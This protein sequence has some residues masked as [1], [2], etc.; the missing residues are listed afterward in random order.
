MILQGV[1]FCYET[2]FSHVSKVDFLAFAKANGYQI[3]LVYFHLFDSSLNEA[4]V[5]QRVS[6]GGHN[7]PADKI[8]SRIPRTMKNIKSALSIVDEAKILDNSSKDNPFQ[9]IVIKKDGIFI[10][11][12][13]PLPGWA[14]EL[15][16]E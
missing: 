6:E 2:V 16:P 4:R 15:L 9:Q 5:N 12:V 13:D 7:V 11:M 3:I 1:S 8:H 14:N 10:A